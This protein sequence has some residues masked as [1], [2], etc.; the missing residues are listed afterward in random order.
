MASK[1]TGA[2]LNGIYE[3]MNEMTPYNPMTADTFTDW[4]TEAGDI[5]TMVRGTEVYETPIHSTNM[6]WR[7]APQMSISTTGNKEREPLAKVSRKRYGGGSGAKRN[8]EYEMRYIHSIEETDSYWR[9]TYDDML[10]GLH[11]ELEITAS[12]IRS[13]LDDTANSLHSEIEQTSSYWRAELDDVDNSLHAEILLTASQFRTALDDTANSLHS[14]IVQTSSYW[15]ASLDDATNS[16][17]SEILVTS[18]SIRQYVDD[19]ANSLHGEI[20]TTSSSI[21]QYVDDSTNS[22]HSEIVVTSNSIKQYVDDADNGLRSSI[23]TERN[24]ISL[25]VEGTGSNAH[26]NAAS[27][28]ASINHDSSSILIS[29]DRINLDGETIV[30]KLVGQDIESNGFTGTY[31]DATVVGTNNIECD[32]GSLYPGDVL[33]AAS[34]DSNH[35]LHLLDVKG[36]EVTFSKAVALSGEWDG[37]TYSVSATSGEIIGTA[38]TTSV[39][40]AVEPGGTSVSPNTRINAKIYKDDPSVPTNQLTYTEMVLSEN[41]SSKTVNL[42]VSSLTKGT[43]STANTYNAGWDYGQT[44]R[45]RT[46]RDATS[47]EL[48]I[49]TLDYS[50]RWTIVDTYTASS[51]TTSDIKYTVAAPADRY[52]EGYSD[53]SPSSGV[54]TGRPGTTYDWTFTITKGDSTTKNL[55]IDCS[56]IYTDARTGYT[57]GIFTPTTL[58]NAGTVTVHDRGTGVTARQVLSANGTVYYKA[59]QSQQYYNAGTTTKTAR[60]DSVTAR[61]VLSSGGTVYYQAVAS[62]LYYNAGTTTKTARGD[63]VTAR[64]VLSTGGTVFY[65]AGTAKTYYNAGTTTKTDR[66]DSVTAREVLSSGG[67]VYYQAVASQLYYN[68]GTSTVTAR[69]DSIT[70]RPVLSSGGTLFYTAG[71][72]TTVY[73]GNGS[74]VTGRGSS[75]SVTVQGTVRYFKYH[76]TS[77]TPTSAWY[78]MHTSKPSGTV[79]TVHLP[80]TE[81]TYYQ[82]NGSTVTG[83]GTGYTVTPIGST[84]VR[85]D[86]AG[87]YYKGNGGNYTVQGSAVAVSS[88]DATTLIRLGSSGTYYKGN[89]GSFTVQGSSAGSITPIGTTSV[90]LDSAGTYYK[91]NG[92]DFTVQ[93]S[94]VAVSS[95]DASTLI[96]LGSSGTYYKGNGGDFTVQGSATAVSSIDA[97]SLIRLG[98]ATTMYPGNGGEYTVQGTEQAAYLKTS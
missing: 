77:E 29:A 15:R 39:Y 45:V 80:G 36:H 87:T 59:L 44:Q 65:T 69:G 89:G 72:E 54:A 85:L 50:E 43:I 13:E 23:T 64:P 24:R 92:G 60:G 55:S 40:L 25:V 68:A 67:T 35:V 58:Y 66:G 18:S 51:G 32:E 41:V 53:G 17:H 27:I 37:T 19:S 81:K 26:I 71:T 49:K 96:R 95:I 90:R 22:L 2:S 12:H 6:V 84:S 7:G 70:A 8:D 57:Q 3:R 56:A 48:T 1:V 62:Q 16:L 28:V 21:R 4:S 79:V 73:P 38:P 97:T 10:L 30:S 78:T 74:T 42:S 91:G 86:S 14:E 46:A 83:R 93:G 88:I 31:V 33:I 63:S 82:G 52:S 11:A 34:V 75:V 76:S 47:Q 94:A 20:V 5:V 98:D 9:A 61:E